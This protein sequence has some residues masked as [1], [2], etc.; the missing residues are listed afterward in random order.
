MSSLQPEPRHDL[1]TVLAALNATVPRL[2]LQ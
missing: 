1:I 2:W